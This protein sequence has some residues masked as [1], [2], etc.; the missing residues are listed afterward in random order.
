MKN[1]LCSLTRKLIVFLLLSCLASSF[2]AVSVFAASSGQTA[3]ATSNVILRQGAASDTKA[4]TTVKKGSTVEI[5]SFQDGWAQVKYGSQT[6]Y[7]S[8]QYLSLQLPTESAATPL[9]KGSEGSVVEA[10]QKA[11]IA[12]GYLKADATGFYGSATQSAVKAFQKDNHLSADGVAGEKTQSVIAAKS[13]SSG[14]SSPVPV[15]TGAAG[16][17]KGAEGAAVKA[18]Q[19]KLKALSYFSGDCTGFF[20]AMTESA[21]KKFQLRNALDEDGIAGAKTLELLE[22]AYASLGTGAPSPSASNAPLSYGSENEAVKELQKDLISL[23]YLSADATG[24]FGSATYKALKRFQK[25][26]GLSSDGVAGALTLSAISAK[27]AVSSASVS[28]SG[29]SDKL[30]APPQES[31]PAPSGG[32]G[33]VVLEDWWSGYI[34]S[35]Y[36]RGQLATVTDVLTG[37]SFK[38]ARFGGENH[39]DAEPLTA[40][41]SATYFKIFNHVTTW[42]ARAIHIQIGGITYAAA[43]NG[44]PHGGENIKSNNFAG[45]FCIHFYNSRTH[46]GNSVNADMQEKVMQAY[47]TPPK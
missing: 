24:Y 42:A 16:L 14:S 46:G 6:G 3:T 21:V 36:K 7:A 35:H 5:L 31:S 32:N 13:S 29:T 20:G 17:Q 47:N 38:I 11:L 2:W 12:L 23:G 34:D 27:K 43:M 22:K 1:R 26:N 37:L 45:Q 25:E 15:E 19:E 33:K 18:L 8:A 44:M 30:P 4:L 41:D 28:L 10:L 9:K 39:L 40:T